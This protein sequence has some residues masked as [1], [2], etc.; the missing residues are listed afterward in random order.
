[1]SYFTRYLCNR[2][3]HD[4]SRWEIASTTAWYGMKPLDVKIQ[5]RECIR[6]HC[7]YTQVEMIK[8]IVDN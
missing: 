1:M 3:K 5:S 2:G 8:V 6:E 7:G 4:F